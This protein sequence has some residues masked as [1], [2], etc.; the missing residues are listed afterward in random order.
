MKANTAAPQVTGYNSDYVSFIVLYGSVA[1]PPGDFFALYPD[2]YRRQRHETSVNGALFL[3][4][5]N[6]MRPYFLWDEL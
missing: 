2:G 1:V 4:C 6:C 5:W 3:H